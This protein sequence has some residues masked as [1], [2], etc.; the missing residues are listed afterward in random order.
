MVV[1]YTRLTVR[2]QMQDSCIKGKHRLVKRAL[3]KQ[4]NALNLCFADLWGSG[5]YLQ[6][7]VIVIFHCVSKSSSSSAYKQT[8]AIKKSLCQQEAHRLFIFSFAVRRRKK[9]NF[10]CQ[11]QVGHH[12]KYMAATCGS[13]FSCKSTSVRVCFLSQTCLVLL[14]QTC[15][16][17]DIC[18]FAFPRSLF[19]GFHTYKNTI[20]YNYPPAEPHRLA[21]LASNFLSVM[22]AF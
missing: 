5:M 1:V 8:F 13:C 3:G 11:Q 15:H 10:Y 19:Q 22:Y 14:K 7:R 2:V 12:S 17:C 21:H 20:V 9:K 18:P 6:T 4:I 16:M